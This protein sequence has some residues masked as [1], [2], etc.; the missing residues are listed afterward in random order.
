M[1]KILLVLLALLGL[2]VLA[3]AQTQTQSG[4][5]APDFQPNSSIDNQGVRRYRVGPG[6][7]LDVRVFGQSDLNGQYAIDDDGN[8][9]SLPF[10]DEPIPAK[11]RNE[12]EIQKAI[13][14][15]YAKYIVKPRVSVR[16]LERRSRQP[17]VVFGAVRLPSRVAM[18][19][20]PIARFS[21]AG[22]PRTIC[23]RL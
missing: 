8:I 3:F 11:C 20:P 21:S 19:R 7:L 6:D 17:A 18:N 23:V 9:S 14:D 1:N 15:A 12:K 2:P 22:S 16:I 5:N 13:T 4:G 10:I